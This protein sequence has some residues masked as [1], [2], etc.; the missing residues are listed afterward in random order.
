MSYLR[1]SSP[2]EPKSASLSL[3]AGE[4]G[5]SVQIPPSVSKLA[6]RVADALVP[7]R[8]LN[9]KLE[10]VRKVIRDENERSERRVRRGR[11]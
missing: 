8:R 10:E 4:R 11:P 1:S 3:C 9:R 6:S 7:E 2:A 5:G